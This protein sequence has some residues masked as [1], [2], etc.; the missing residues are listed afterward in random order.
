METRDGATD[1]G[2]PSTVPVELPETVLPP[3]PPPLAPAG[4]LA[5]QA[6]AIV[7][8]L[9]DASAPRDPAVLAAFAGAH[10]PVVLA[11]GSSLT[12]AD[13]PV[14]YPWSIV[15]SATTLS[16]PRT[17]VS[18]ANLVSMFAL[19]DPSRPLDTAAVA[20][21]LVVG[22]RAALTA[23]EP[24]GPTFLALLVAEEARR[25]RGVELADP[26][27]HADQLFVEST[28]AMLITASAFRAVYEVL[29][30]RQLAGEPFDGE[31][32]HDTATTSPATTAAGPSRVTHRPTPNSPFED[33]P[34]CDDGQGG[35]LLWVSSKIAT[36][37]NIF[38]A[39]W[40][41]IYLTLSEFAYSRGRIIYEGVEAIKDIGKATAVGGALINVAILQ[42]QLSHRYGEATLNGSG[43]LIRTKTTSDGQS[44]TITLQIAYGNGDPKA[45]LARNCLLAGLVVAGNNAQL[46]L[47]TASGVEVDTTGE[48]GFTKN[49]VTAGTLVLF[50]PDT[51]HPTQ[52]ASED[53]RITI[54]VQGRRQPYD[55]SHVDKTVD[56]QFSLFFEASLDPV[57]ASTIGRLLADSVLCLGTVSV[58]DV[59][60]AVAECQNAVIDIIKQF[61]WDLGEFFFPLTDWDD[62][63]WSANGVV[64]PYTISGIKCGG[65]GG[66]WDIY[67][68]SATE[69]FSFAGSMLG[70][71]DPETLTGQFSFDGLATGSGASIHVTGAGLVTFVQNADGTAS[72]EISGDV[73]GPRGSGASSGAPVSVPLTRNADCSEYAG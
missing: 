33:N 3:I 73:F 30:D 41:G 62:A 15:S 7:D 58:G 11:D 38:G 2:D 57:T 50:G 43:P 47:G 46:A 9:T 39:E 61:H 8:V 36:G 53:G 65:V 67:M 48:L 26:T 23:P 52:T 51:F 22:L 1:E 35:W 24:G 70:E 54:P 21:E 13:D 14:G 72:L 42:A 25:N 49:L 66:T 18:L 16:S 44:R 59:V 71:I 6:S 32:S 29:I 34:G 64:F 12:T 68:E 45:V 27:V 5:E 28:V 31:S 4:T 63:G 20:E 37:A 40:K 55:K 69:S 10:L 17:T 56:K 60:D 19:V